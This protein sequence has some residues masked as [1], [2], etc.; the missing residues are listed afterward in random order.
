MHRHRV[1]RG[2][3]VIFT[4]LL[5]RVVFTVVGGSIEFPSPHNLDLFAQCD[6]PAILNQS[7]LQYQ[8]VRPAPLPLSSLPLSS[9]SAHPTPPTPM[10]RTSSPRSMS[11]RARSRGRQPLSDSEAE[12]ESMYLLSVIE[13]DA[14]RPVVG[15]FSNLVPPSARDG[16]SPPLLHEGTPPISSRPRRAVNISLPPLCR[17][18]YNPD[19]F[20]SNDDD[21]IS[22]SLSW[23]QSLHCSNAGL[24]AVPQPLP[25]SL[26]YM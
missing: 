12:Q 4:I 1:P 11:P 9:T 25:S 8:P 5:S 19:Y 20:G 23:P 24:T 21:A 14:P 13:R 7:S 16:L 3:H 2:P 18:S 26:I 22:T 10:P 6:S 15:D 17:A